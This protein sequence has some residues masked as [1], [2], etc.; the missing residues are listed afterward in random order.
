MRRLCHAGVFNS[1][2][3][4]FHVLH[5]FDI[6]FC[7]GAKLRYSFC[8][9]KFYSNDV[10]LSFY[11]DE[12]SLI[13]VASIWLIIVSSIQLLV[14]GVQYACIVVKVGGKRKTQ[15]VCKKH[16]NFTK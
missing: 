6:N 15:K 9:S 11:I 5:D 10:L 2:S 16:V 14:R 13:E 7:L 12:N 8:Q 4:I 1:C 3:C